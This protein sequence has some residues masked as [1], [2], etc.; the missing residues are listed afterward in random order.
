MKKNSKPKISVRNNRRRRNGRENRR[1]NDTLH[2]WSLPINV[3]LVIVG[4]VVLGVSY[5][6]IRNS[7]D[8]L[9]SE[10]ARQETR[11]EDLMDEL[12]RER[13][14]WD[15]MKTPRGLE[16]RLLKHGIAMSS[17]RPGQ[18][19]AMNAAPARTGNAAASSEYAYTR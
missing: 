12:R 4:L 5:A 17:P 14:K 10:I 8:S 15:N 13:T 3:S 18:R 7:C 6:V 19:I 1:W 16:T 11:Q 2:V 9:Q